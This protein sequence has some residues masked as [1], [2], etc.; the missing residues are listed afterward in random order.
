LIC[1]SE[2][3]EA[4]ARQDAEAE[5]DLIRDPQGVTKLGVKF[6]AGKA[7]E[8]DV[9][10]HPKSDVS[11]E[12]FDADDAAHAPA[13]EQQQQQQQQRQPAERQG[14]GDQGDDAPP[15]LETVEG[16][17][18]LGMAGAA[19]A[20]KS[21]EASSSDRS[22]PRL[23]DEECDEGMARQ[24]PAQGALQQPAPPADGAVEVESVLLQVD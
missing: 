7:Q 6:W 19:E 16:S 22:E 15:P 5:R 14:E 17:V 18:P 9:F 12:I 11:S 8:Y 4:A 1:G 13:P 20:P 23:A 3:R 21:E 10:G 24:G 2:E